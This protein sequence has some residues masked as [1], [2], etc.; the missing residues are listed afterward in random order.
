[1]VVLEPA[2]RVADL[3]GRSGGRSPTVVV[4]GDQCLLAAV[5]VGTPE[6]TGGVVGESQFEGDLRQGLAVEMAVND[7]QSGLQ[8][9]GT[10]HG[11]ISW[12]PMG[13]NR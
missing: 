1:V 4:S 12:G 6:G 9:E 5:A 7:L 13:A 3:D 8:R 10:G 11:R 2:S